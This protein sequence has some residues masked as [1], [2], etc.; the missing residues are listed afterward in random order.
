[1]RRPGMKNTKSFVYYRWPLLTA[2]STALLNMTAF[3]EA[4][5]Y[6]LAR[7][8]GVL[9]RYIFI[10]L[11]QGVMV[12]LANRFPDQCL[13]QRKQNQRMDITGPWKTAR[14]KVAR[15]YFDR[16]AIVVVLRSDFAEDNV[17]FI[18][19]FAQDERRPA[20]YIS[21]ESGVENA[22]FDCVVPTGATT[23]RRGAAEGSPWGWQSATTRRSL[24]FGPMN[25]AYGRD[26]NPSGELVS[27][28][29]TPDSHIAQIRKRKRDNNHITG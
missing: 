15:C 3:L 6:P 23:F 7:V 19:G 22:H 13:F 16:D 28:D 1:M 29:S 11:S 10:G 27:T 9:K 25:R 20:F 17:P 5:P 26:D 18:I 21:C 12:Y 2:A 8:I 24:R 4:A 14:F